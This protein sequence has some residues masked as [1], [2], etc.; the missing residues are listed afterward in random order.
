MQGDARPQTAR[1]TQAVV[2]GTR[3]AEDPRLHPVAKTDLDGPPPW[4]GELVA[5]ALREELA[6]AAAKCDVWEKAV[7]HAGTKAGAWPFERDS[8]GVRLIALEA[9]DLVVERLRPR[10][11]TGHAGA[12]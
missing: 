11:W 7:A 3:M 5:E 2:R 10:H 4:A 1:R 8:V 12:A 6:W 9:C